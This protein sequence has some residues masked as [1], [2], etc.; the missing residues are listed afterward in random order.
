MNKKEIKEYYE[1]LIA[2]KKNKEGLFSNPNTDVFFMSL[3]IDYSKTSLKCIELGYGTG[4]YAEY[5]AER[6][7]FVTAVDLV[8]K[9]LLQNRLAGKSYNGNIAIIQ[10]DIESF[11][12]AK[13]NYDVVIARNVLH[14]LPRE[15]VEKILLEL[16]K[17]TKKQGVHYI[18]LFTDIV[19]YDRNDNIIVFP[20]EAQ[21]STS[22]AVDV[23]KRIYSGW[24]VS[25]N[26]EKYSELDESGLFNYFSAD[27]IYIIAQKNNLL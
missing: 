1:K 26:I 4:R 25:I 11:S 8:D 17:H 10:S 3:P 19:R 18:T 5:L 22:Y 23:V 6:G 9:T 14:Y 2:N 13:I 12:M 15:S 21:Y 24:D 20:E 7:I 27:C 16:V